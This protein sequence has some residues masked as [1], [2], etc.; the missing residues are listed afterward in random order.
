MNKLIVVCAVLVAGLGFA[1]EKVKIPGEGKI[2]I[3]NACGVS[4]A[5]LESV[6][7]KLEGFLMV[8]MEVKEGKWSLADA[9]SS[10]DAVKANAA[11]FVI[12]DKGLP[13]SLVA[14]ESKWGVVNAE[15]LND[16][17]VEKETLRVLTMV[18]GG[19]SSKYKTSAMRAVFSKADL[20]LAG[21]VLAFDSLMSVFN[22]LPDLGVKQYRIMD[23][24]DAIE[25]G[26]IK[27]NATV[28]A[29]AKK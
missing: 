14:V 22:Y 8:D 24:E 23:R 6:V 16:V 10:F 5:P 15:G 19:A 1:G 25:E 2:A 27:T 11:V 20:A 3:V 17:E 26:L 12:K 21:D 18:L 7:K 29:E 4:K 13:L 9:K 28:S